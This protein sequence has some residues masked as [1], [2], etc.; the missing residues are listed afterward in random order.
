MSKTSFDINRLPPNGYLIIPL[1]MSRLTKDQSPKKIYEFLNS[2]KEKIKEISVDVILL[3]TN[4]L[5]MNAESKGI[6]I[7]EKT[8]KQM[9]NH[10]NEF[11]KLIVKER[12][13]VPQ[14]FHFLPWDYTIINGKD[15]EMNVSRLKN[16]LQKNK[17]FQKQ[18]R[19]DLKSIGKPKNKSNVNFLIEE[20]V[21][22]H[23][24][25]NKLIPLPHTLTSSD[26]W[27]LIAYNGDVLKLDIYIY[28]NKILPENPRIINSKLF[29]HSMY[30]ITKKKLINFDEK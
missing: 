2:F 10:K 27:R 29:T 9:L 4:G 1:S 6:D 13:F 21:I 30:N 16:A 26:G 12:E 17:E 20:L 28:K 24:L 15:Y 5:Y 18:L 11:Y 19:N 14:A 25:R 23:L 8:L 22:T 7:R 3:Y